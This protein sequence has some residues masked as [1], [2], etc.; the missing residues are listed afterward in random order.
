MPRCLLGLVM[1][2]SHNF[3]TRSKIKT[4]LDDYD[5][6]PHLRARMFQRGVTKGEIEATLREGWEAD[7]AKPRTLGKV[8]VFPYN[9][10]WEGQFF[11]EKEVRV[12]YKLECC[13]LALRCS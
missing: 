2:L 3:A 11:E 7:D 8:S 5:L 12:Y 6:H 9:D 10:N 13:I 4:R 1:M